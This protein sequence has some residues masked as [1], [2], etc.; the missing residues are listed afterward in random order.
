MRVAMPVAKW[1]LREVARDDDELAVA[2]AVLVGGEFHR[3]W[4]DRVRCSGESRLS[5]LA[6]TVAGAA[7][8]SP[9]AVAAIGAP[10]R[11]RRALAGWVALTLILHAGA[12][13]RP[14]G[15]DAD[16]VVSGHGTD[17]GAH[18]GDRGRNLPL[19]SADGGGRTGGRPGGT[20]ATASAGAGSTRSSASGGRSRQARDESGRSLREGG[21][22]SAIGLRGRR[23]RRPGVLRRRCRRPRSRPNWPRVDRLSRAPSRPHRRARRRCSRPVKCRHP[24]TAPG[25]RRRRRCATRCV[26]VSCAVPARSADARRTTAIASCSRPG[27]PA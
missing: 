14:G 15:L 13:R 9:V 7:A 22:N 18:G 11:R 3:S 27:S 19:S 8:R 21:R 2:R 25:C 4:A 5:M 17:V 1:A 26:V 10:K 20:R 6:D 23:G 24:P 16:R 12:S